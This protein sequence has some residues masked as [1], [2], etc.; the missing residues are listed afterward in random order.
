MGAATRTSVTIT[1]TNFSSM[2]SV[3]FDGAMASFGVLSS[4][5]LATITPART[6]GAVDVVITTTGGSATAVGAF[7]Y[8]SG[9]GI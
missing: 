3:T 6:S 9:P 5:T 4:T 1:G 7:V 2:I 8:I